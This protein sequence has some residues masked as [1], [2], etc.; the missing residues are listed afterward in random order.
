MQSVQQGA[1]QQNQN[2]KGNNQRDAAPVPPAPQTLSPKQAAEAMVESGVTRHAQRID[3][4][5]LKAIWGGIFLSYGGF[6]ESVVGGSSSANA[7][8]P[9]LLRLVEG[10]VFPVGL[11]MIVLT[12]SELLTSD[13]M[14]FFMAALKGRIPWWGVIYAYVVVFLGNLAGSLFFGM[15]L[16]RYTGLITGP[17][18]TFV[19]NAAVARAVTPMWHELFLRGIGC[20]I[21][22]C[23]A[24]Y[25]ASQGSDLFSKV[26]GIWI[27]L[28]T[29]VVLQYEHVVA[30]MFTLPLGI[31]LNAPGVSIGLY[32]WKTMIAALIGN[33][34]GAV[35][36]SLTFYWLYLHPHGEHSEAVENGHMNGNGHVDAEVAGKPAKKR[37]MGPFGR[38][39]YG[40]P[41]KLQK[42][43]WHESGHTRH[44]F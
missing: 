13:M 43:L 4:L 20:N 6:F 10:L 15:I 2:E 29:F 12:G 32:I 44:H 23:M 27:P 25:L 36:L 39:S 26:V 22:V 1:N 40:N 8:N 11:A 17:I 35:L 37:K 5:F 33:F 19:Q 31:A 9:G 28:S 7:N 18:S 21:M 34:V 41:T 24:V 14:F 30:D 3:V 16:V 42:S 38:G